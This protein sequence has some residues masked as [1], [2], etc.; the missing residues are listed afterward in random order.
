MLQPI[1]NISV[2]LDGPHEPNV[3]RILPLLFVRV[4]F[5]TKSLGITSK[6]TVESRC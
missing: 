1:D 6:E 4:I 3:V 5:V 2:N